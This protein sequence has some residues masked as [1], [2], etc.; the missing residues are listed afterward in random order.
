[1]I[2][3]NGDCRGDANGPMSTSAVWN[4]NNSPPLVPAVSSLSV[5]PF[6]PAPARDS[7]SRPLITILHQSAD[8]FFHE[9]VRVVD[10]GPLSSDSRGWRLEL[11]RLYADYG[12]QFSM[13]YKTAARARTA[14]TAAGDSWTPTLT[15]T[16]V[17]KRSDRKT[18]AARS[19]DRSTTTT[20][21]GGD[22][23]S[24]KK[25][26]TSLPT[27]S[28]SS[29]S[30]SNRKRADARWRPSVPHWL[31]KPQRASTVALTPPVHDLFIA[32]SRRMS[33]RY[34]IA[35]VVKRARGAR[36]Y[37]HTTQCGIVLAPHLDGLG[38][39]DHREPQRGPRGESFWIFSIKWCIL[40]HF[41]FLSDVWAP[42]RPGARGSLPSYSTLSTSLR[43][44]TVVCFMTHDR[45]R[46]LRKR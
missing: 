14:T 35:G 16:G 31:C 9:P 1:M 21:L 23:L 6:H 39:A 30:S 22:D 4:V 10:G 5:R 43:I 13:L 17:T 15:R 8:E 11:T 18:S 26:S 12:Y 45:S 7:R 40:M 24:R 28:S 2:G 27:V 41:I 42:K 19:G 29:S 34:G 38:Y 25:S 46:K 3:T 20:S 32:A 37:Y 33:T 44:C 36:L